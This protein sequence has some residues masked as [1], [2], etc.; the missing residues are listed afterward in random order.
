[1]TVDEFKLDYP[2]TLE[3]R[4]EWAEL[5]TFQHVNNTVYF[6]YFERVRIAFFEHA[7]FVVPGRHDGAGPILHSTRCR[8]RVPL[9]YPDTIS[10]GVLIGAVQD[11]RFLMQYGIYSHKLAA[12]AAE[13]DGLLV[14]YDYGK[15]GK[16]LLP[17]ELKTKLLSFTK[18]E[19]R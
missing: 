1:M 11:D 8:F 14:Y 19:S 5:D 10:M 18:A 13:G 16:A 17:P 9:T 2:F 15:G 3:G 12:L 7:G 6:R 4:V